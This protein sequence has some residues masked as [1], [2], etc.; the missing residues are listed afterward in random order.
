M[1]DPLT[2]NIRVYN[3]GPPTAVPAQ[4]SLNTPRTSAPSHEPPSSAKKLEFGKKPVRRTP[5]VRMLESAMRSARS[6]RAGKGPPSEMVM[7][8]RTLKI[9]AYSK[10]VPTASGRRRR[11]VVEAV[12]LSRPPAPAEAEGRSGEW[13]ATQG[14]ALASW[15]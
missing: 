7:H 3:W 10:K 2:D 5:T 1:R 6:G 8:A 4:T 13:Y 12:T 14:R 11:L 15:T 9:C